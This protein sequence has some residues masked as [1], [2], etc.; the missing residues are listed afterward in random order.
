MQLCVTVVGGGIVGLWQALTMADGGI[1][2]PCVKPPANLLLARP[3]VSPA[4]CSPPTARLR[5][6]TR[7]FSNS[8]FAASGYGV[9]LDLV[10]IG[11][12][13]LW[14]PIPVMPVSWSASGALRT[15][16]AFS[17]RMK[18]PKQS[19]H[20]PTDSSAASCM[21]GKGTW[22]RARCSLCFSGVCVELAPT[23]V[24]RRRSPI[25]SGQPQ[26]QERLS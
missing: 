1:V 8:V 14:S 9:R 15:A 19:Q 26:A 25:Q 20:Y 4:Q 23:S 18:S 2:S 5:H 21:S 7:L 3:A 17:T 11:G 10:L 24:L 12:G 13:P 6:R 22:H 16:I